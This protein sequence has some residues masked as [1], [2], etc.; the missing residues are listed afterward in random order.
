MPVAGLPHVASL[1]V[2][3]LPGAPHSQASK[4]SCISAAQGANPRGGGQLDELPQARKRARAA[5]KNSSYVGQPSKGHRV[6][7]GTEQERLRYDK[8]NGRKTKK[9]GALKIAKEKV[10]WLSIT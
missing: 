1:P 7:C 10:P 6:E 2:A 8:V 4:Q 3:G 9:R 5:P